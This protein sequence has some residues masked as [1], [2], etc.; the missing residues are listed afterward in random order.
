MKKF[1]L[2]ALWFYAGWTF[3]SMI[4]FALGLGVALGPIVA[5][6][7]AAVVLRAPQLTAS[8]QAA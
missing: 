2:A 1:F 8:R 6:V 4:S 5:I 3:G 7:A